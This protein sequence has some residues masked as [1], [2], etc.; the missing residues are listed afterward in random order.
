MS[1]SPPITVLKCAHIEKLSGSGVEPKVGK[2]N[3]ASIHVSKTSP[4]NQKMKKSK[5]KCIRQNFQECIKEKQGWTGI[6]TTAYQS[7]NII[8]YHIFPQPLKYFTL[9]YMYI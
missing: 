6:T 9:S 2:Q 4:Q 1:S 8:A 3:T 5:S 7:K